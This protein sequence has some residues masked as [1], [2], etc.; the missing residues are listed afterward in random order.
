MD[1]DT[2]LAAAGRASASILCLCLGSAALLLACSPGGKTAASDQAPAAPSAQT[3]VA[4]GPCRLLT[5]AE[6]RSVFPG[7]QA[8]KPERTREQYGIQACVWDTPSGSFALQRWTADPGESADKELRGLAT[9]ILD[10]LKSTA[11][12]AVRFE[13]LAGI[14]EQATALVERKD[15]TRGVLSDAAILV[16]KKGNWFLELQSV[17]LARAERTVALQA[18]GKLGRLATERL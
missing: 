7:A 5:D 13:V 6:V 18:L 3:A 15:D 11:R 17:D 1:P 14:G 9:G 4:A 12:T 10:P 16:A 2:R 8:G